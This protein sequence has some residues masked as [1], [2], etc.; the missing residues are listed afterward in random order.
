MMPKATEPIFSIG[1]DTFYGLVEWVPGGVYHSKRTTKKMASSVPR[2]RNPL[3]FTAARTED[4]VAGP[5]V[6][7]AERP[8]LPDQ[9]QV[10]SMLTSDTRAPP[11][12]RGRGLG[13]GADKRYDDG[14]DAATRGRRRVTA[15]QSAA[16]FPAASAVDKPKKD[17]VLRQQQRVDEEG[18]RSSAWIER[19]RADARA[20][21]MHYDSETLLATVVAGAAIAGGA[22]LV[23]AIVML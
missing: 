18:M 19:A 11:S 15:F 2:M 7:G 3:A 4:M 13:G 5:A 10:A 12:H 9:F 8:R 20:T 14:D 23:A 21:K 16:S 22:M 17:D 1:G 6:M